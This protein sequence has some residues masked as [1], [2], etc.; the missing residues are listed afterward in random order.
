MTVVAYPVPT[1]GKIDGAV[2]GIHRLTYDA[3]GAVALHLHSI[4]LIVLETR[5]FTAPTVIL[6][7]QPSVGLTL[8]DQYV[9]G[10]LAEDGFCIHIIGLDEERHPVPSLLELCGLFNLIESSEHNRLLVAARQFQGCEGNG[11][12]RQFRIEGAGRSVVGTEGDLLAGIVVSIDIHGDE[13]A[14]ITFDISRMCHTS[15]FLTDEG[16]HEVIGIIHR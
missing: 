8:D 2:G 11:V 6:A 16:G 1:A 4:H 3:Q 13:V 14:V 10:H 7:H 15:T 5:E 12:W 9:V